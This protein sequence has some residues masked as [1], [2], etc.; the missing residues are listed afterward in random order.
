[1]RQ[2]TLA[3]TLRELETRREEK[4]A[5]EAAYLDVA[6]RVPEDLRNWLAQAG[7]LRGYDDAKAEAAHTEMLLR[8]AQDELANAQAR[9]QAL[10]AELAVRMTVPEAQPAAVG[11]VGA[12]RWGHLR[13]GQLLARVFDTLRDA[14]LCE[15][16]EVRVVALVD[17]DAIVPLASG[18]AARWRHDQLDR[19]WHHRD[20]AACAGYGTV[21]P[22]YPGLAQP[23]QERDA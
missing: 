7:Y 21:S 10:A 18:T 8:E 13:N 16:H 11:V 23:A 15:A 17:P 20:L 2:Q 3:E 19:V 5:A 1:M 14:T 9:V 6:D 12:V 4:R 22:L